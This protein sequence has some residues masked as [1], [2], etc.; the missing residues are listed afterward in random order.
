MRSYWKYSKATICRH[1]KKNI[2]DLVVD[3]RKNNQG[4]PPKLSLRQKRNILRQTKLLQEEMG[5]FCVKRVMVKVGIPP[6]ISEDRFG[7]VLRKAGLKWAR[8][9]RNGT[10]TKNDLKL[11][12]K[13]ARKVCHKLPGNFWEERVGYYLDG[14]S[15]IHKMN[16]FDQARAPRALSWKK[17]G[18]GFDFGFTEKQVMKAQEGLLLT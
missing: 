12:L 18:Q 11:S 3:L 17:P 9:Q 16:L 15:F 6:S 13:F 5:N 4:R 14:A 2:G 10:L 7:R 1:M 8:V